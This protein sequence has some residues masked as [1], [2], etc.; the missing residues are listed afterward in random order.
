MEYISPN[1]FNI[2]E[3][4]CRTY[5]MESSSELK[6]SVD[7]AVARDVVALK[8]H[9]D[10]H[11]QLPPEHDGVAAT[12]AGRVYKTESPVPVECERKNKHQK[13]EQ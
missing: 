6:T 4:V 5:R 10:V 8:L 12:P 13:H 1:I 2:H 7:A 9:D 3:F 11:E